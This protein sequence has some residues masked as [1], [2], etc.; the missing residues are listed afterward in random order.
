MLHLDAT[1]ASLTPG[2]KTQTEKSSIL[3]VAKGKQKF[4][5]TCYVVKESPYHI[6]SCS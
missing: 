3:G 4:P 2:Q 5:Y 1:S 6:E